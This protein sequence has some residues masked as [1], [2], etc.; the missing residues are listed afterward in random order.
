MIEGQTIE[1]GDSGEFPSGK[2]QSLCDDLK[3]LAKEGF[4]TVL[5]VVPPTD[6]QYDKD[7][8]YPILRPTPVGKTIALLAE[9]QSWGYEARLQRVFSETDPT[10]TVYL[11]VRV[12]TRGHRE[13]V[14][15]EALL[16][17]KSE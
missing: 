14:S 16:H 17:L 1:R 9:I 2:S 8:D 12:N 11:K 3:R 10:G 5:L 15:S 7:A 6:W 4:A 13:V